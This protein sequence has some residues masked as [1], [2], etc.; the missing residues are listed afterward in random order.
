[1]SPN[2]WTLPSKTKPKISVNGC[3][4]AINPKVIVVNR[5]I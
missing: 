1:M 3:K 4:I 2:A 5:G